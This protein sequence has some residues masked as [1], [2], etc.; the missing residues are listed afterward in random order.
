VKKLLPVFLA[1]VGPTQKVEPTPVPPLPTEIPTPI[2]P[3]A[4]PATPTDVPTPIPPTLVP[5]TET[6]VPT[7]VEPTPTSIITNTQPIEQGIF[8]PKIVSGTEVVFEDDFTDSSLDWPE[9]SSERI[10]RA[11][12]DG[13]FYMNVVSDRRQGWNYVLDAVYNHDVVLDVDVRGGMD[14]PEDGEAG[15]VCGFEDGDNFYA[16]SVGAHGYIE[17]FRYLDNE[18]ERLYEAYDVLPLDP[19]GTHL[20]GVCTQSELSLYVNWQLVGT[21]AID[22]L[23]AGTAGLVGGSNDTGNVELYFDNFII[24]KGPYVFADGTNPS[25][26]QRSELLLMDDFSNENSGWDVRTTDDGG[27]TTYENGEYRMNVIETNHDAWSN[28]NDDVIT[29]NVIVDVEVRMGSNPGDG[30]A[31]ILCN[32]NMSTNGDFTVIGID[33]EGYGRIYDYIDRDTVD[34]FKSESPITLN[35]QVNHLTAHCIDSMV[36]LLV[37]NQLIASTFTNAPKADNVGLLSGTYDYGVTDFYYDNF[38]VYSIR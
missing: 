8:I 14:F 15:F 18:R 37:N 30:I 9:R 20:T 10:T 4:V 27:F 17:F 35:P 24:S 6:P 32:Y 16:M 12:V 11:F 38:E 3:T 21:Y 2:S 25:L 13:E 19:A 1:C 7:I 22:G 28:P 34:L 31:A 29:G 5:P 23:P 36:T 26:G 33:G